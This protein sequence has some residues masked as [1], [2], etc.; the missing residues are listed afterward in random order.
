MKKLSMRTMLAG[1]LFLGT[2]GLVLLRVYD[3]ASSRVF[4]PCPLHYLTGLYCPGCGS[5]RAIH[6]LLLGNLRDAWAMNPLTCL[7]LPFLIYG[8]AS[9]A[10]LRLRGRGL[11]QVF[12][13]AASIR[14]L[15]AVIVLFGILRNL[16][17]R[18][19]DLLAPGAMLR[20]W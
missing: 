10:L 14:A 9:Q 18:P 19:F 15:C 12:L 5:L 13:P 1:S 8:L 16:P 20:L 2:I 4:P 6:Q 17:I 7:L 11:P 3:P